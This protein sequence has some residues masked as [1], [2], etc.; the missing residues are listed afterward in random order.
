MAEASGFKASVYVLHIGGIALPCYA[1]L[2]SLVLN[3]AVSV[4][5]SLVFNAMS[6]TRNDTTA[7]EDYA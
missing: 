6:N 4:V 5:L 7:A 2:S 3:I 1:A